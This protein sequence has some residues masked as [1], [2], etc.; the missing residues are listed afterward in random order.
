MDVCRPIVCLVCVGSASRHPLIPIDKTASSSFGRREINRGQ[1][2]SHNDPEA[3]VDTSII[4]TGPLITLLPANPAISGRSHHRPI[5]SSFRL[6]AEGKGGGVS[7]LTSVGRRGRGLLL[8]LWFTAIHLDHCPCCHRTHHFKRNSSPPS[9]R[10]TRHDTETT[11]V[12]T[13]GETT[14]LSPTQ[15]LH[16]SFGHPRVADVQLVLPKTHH[17]IRQP[18]HPSLH[19]RKQS[20]RKRQSPHPSLYIAC[21]LDRDSPWPSPCVSS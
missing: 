6:F 3:F 11:D 5:R 12:V 4:P 13:S 1:A 21:R 8:Y 2:P 15:T 20:F 10:L 9:F 7:A 19:D 16:H 14:I 17:R 18:R